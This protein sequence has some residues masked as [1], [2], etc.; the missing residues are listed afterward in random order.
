MTHKLHCLPLHRIMEFW[1]KSVPYLIQH[2]HWTEWVE[3]NITYC[4]L[5]K[6]KQLSVIKGA[7]V[8]FW[9]SY[10]S[11]KAHSPK[12][13][14]YQS[15][16]I[17]VE[18]SLKYCHLQNWISPLL[19]QMSIFHYIF[20]LNLSRL[21]I[22]N[23]RFLILSFVKSVPILLFSISVHPCA[24]IPLIA[25]DGKWKPFLITHSVS[26]AYPIHPLVNIYWFIIHV[27]LI[28]YVILNF[29]STGCH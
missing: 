3:A 14:D 1:N 11:T 10:W 23:F 15:R 29:V 18:L 13:G 24:S 26:L 7:C 5:F 9:G 28:I 17:P 27:I 21:M 12:I 19:L 25:H 4:D 20:L 8:Y 22:P 16:S 6:G 2:L